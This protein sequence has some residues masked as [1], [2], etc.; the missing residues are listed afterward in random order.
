MNPSTT[1]QQRM[2]PQF[3]F[4]LFGCALLI[5]LVLSINF[6]AYALT[7]RDWQDIAASIIGQNNT[8]AT[9]VF[10]QI[11][12]PRVILA[13]V[14]GAGLG[15]VGSA[16]QD[17]FRNPMA[18]PGL[19]GVS[20]G[21]AL[22]VGVVM[23]LG[24]VLFPSFA[25]TLSIFTYPAAAFIGG[26]VVTWLIY[27]LGSSNQGVS[28]QMMLLAGIAINVLCESM[29][30][31]LNYIAN[32][33]QLRQF[34]NWR[35]GSLAGQSWIVVIMCSSLVAI[36]ALILLPCARGLN[37]M[38]LSEADAKSMGINVVRLKQRIVVGATLAVGAVVS[39]AGMVMFVGLAAPHLVRLMC[40]PNQK[41]VMA[42]SML[43]GAGLTLLADAFARQL[44]S[45][46]EIPLSIPLALLGA[47]LFIHLLRKAKQEHAL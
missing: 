23:V 17:L 8:A 16:L 12:V 42:G 21:S 11:R 46:A 43:L 38:A 14:V 20:S 18:D 44:I 33:E 4:T 36:S 5:G 28:V 37:L 26:V 39:S 30:A 10:W 40:G 22:A 31:I 3:F 35:M 25:K 47:P 45:P 32:D 29:I 34:N 7:W 2:N 15:M 1:S 27:R 9:T 19:L 41:Y 6:G 24:S 13:T